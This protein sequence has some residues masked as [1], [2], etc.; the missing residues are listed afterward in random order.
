MIFALFVFALFA[1]TR[2]EVDATME[3]LKQENAK[4][5]TQIEEALAI[6][7]LKQENAALMAQIEE[8]V[9][10]KRSPEKSRICEGLTNSGGDD[11]CEGFSDF[12]EGEDNANVRRKCSK[13]CCRIMGVVPEEAK[14]KDD[15]GG[16]RSPEKSQEP[17]FVLTL[18]EENN[19][20]EPDLDYNFEDAALKPAEPTEPAFIITL[21]EENNFEEPDLEYNFEDAA[22][23]PAEP[24]KPAFFITLE[25][26]NFEERPEPDYV[27]EDAALITCDTYTSCSSCLTDYECIW[28][29]GEANADTGDVDMYEKGKCSSP[30]E[31]DW[32]NPNIMKVIEQT[33]VTSSTSCPKSEPKDKFDCTSKETW[34]KKKKKWCCKKKGMGCKE[35]KPKDKFDCLTREKWSKKKT[36]WCCK[37]KGLGC[38][39]ERSSGPDDS[40]DATDLFDLSKLLD[41]EL[42]KDDTEEDAELKKLE[43][44]MN[45]DQKYEKMTGLKCCKC[46]AEKMQTGAKKG[47]AMCAYQGGTNCRIR[48]EGAKC[49]KAGPACVACEDAEKQNAFEEM[50]SAVAESALNVDH[51]KPVEVAIMYGFAAIGL[52]SIVHGTYSLCRRKKVYEEVKLEEETQE[53]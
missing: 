23:K 52:L 39:A 41:D 51:F 26:E 12:C 11:F 2:A 32:S 17:S 15:S 14:S 1:V 13:T 37:K 40:L 19:F 8:A 49:P 36:K 22:L 35:K 53:V 45:E 3:N 27:I 29:K 44:K 31:V 42:S 5:L 47:N 28:Y 43:D 18:E 46:D 10:G 9:G 20:E 16:K 4:L 34:S 48:E 33:E 6:Q 50:L 30:R 25:E 21:E 24:T 38:K 7:D